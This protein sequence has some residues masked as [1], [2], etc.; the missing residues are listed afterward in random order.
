MSKTF[1]WLVYLLTAAFF[2]AFFLWPI[3][4]TVGG[5]FLDE[6]GKFTLDFITEVF[7]NQIYLEG[8]RNT[9]PLA[10]AS[11]PATPAIVQPAPMIA[12]KR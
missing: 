1:A 9:L 6:D 11:T 2:G 7:R 5:A 8:L 4:A 10:I 3:G 12:T